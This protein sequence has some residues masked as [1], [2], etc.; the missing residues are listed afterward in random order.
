[1]LSCL[2]NP[3]TKEILFIAIEFSLTQV[4]QM[5]KECIQNISNAGPSFPS[6]KLPIYSGH[7]TY[8]AFLGAS[9]HISVSI[10]LAT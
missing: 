10:L 2:G 4:L 6:P 3:S 7:L 8:F 5:E 9:M 1:M